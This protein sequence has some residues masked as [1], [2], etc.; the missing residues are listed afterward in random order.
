[1]RSLE[2]AP[3]DFMYVKAY[4]VEMKLPK[5]KTATEL[6]SNLYETL[7][8]VSEGA[9]QVITHKQGGEVVLISQND[10]NDLVYE[11]EVLRAMANGRAELD[12]GKGIS[13]DEVASH[14]KARR[15][16]WK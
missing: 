8:E 3:L 12:L 10:F 11:R 15:K 2:G 16:K 14:L 9:P 7:K 5:I 6:R 4:A 13:H 1:V